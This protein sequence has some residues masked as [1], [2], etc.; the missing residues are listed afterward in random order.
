MGEW[1]VIWEGTGG[2]VSCNRAADTKGRLMGKAPEGPHVYHKDG[3]YYLLVAEG[4]SPPS[5]PQAGLPL[6]DES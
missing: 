2:E 3:F 1:E 4:M 6:S 5:A